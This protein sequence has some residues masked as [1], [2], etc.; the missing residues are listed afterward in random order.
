MHRTL[1]LTPLRRVSVHVTALVLTLSGCANSDTLA[2]ETDASSAEEVQA[3][4]PLSD[5][6][7]IIERVERTIDRGEDAADSIPMLVALLRDPATTPAEHG[8]ATLALS[9]AYAAVGDAE[10]AIATLE[11][12]L[13]RDSH[14]PNWSP[15]EVRA[16]LRELL[17]GSREAQG[18][19][20]R[21]NVEAP[22]FARLLGKYFPA[23]DDG[24]VNT[25][26]FIVGGDGA[27]SDAIGTFDVAAGLRAQ[28]E[29]DC[30]LC[31]E[32]ISVRTSR[33]RSDWLM[34]PADEAKFG[35]AML[36]F[37]FDLG[38][39]RIPARYERHL[40][41]KVADIER[42]LENDKSFALAAE[43]EGAPPVILI[44]APRT[45]LLE[46][47]EKHLSQLDTLPRTP[48]YVDV[49][50]R[51]R[52]SEIKGVIR[53]AYFASARACYEALLEN[54]DG[55]RG[56]I[57]LGFKIQGDGVATDV[58]IDSSDGSLKAEPF[59]SCLRTVI[60][61]VRFPASGSAI[62]TVRYPIVFAP[63]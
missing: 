25:N 17:T 45:A 22:P 31:T 5:A 48:E 37:Y 63:E 51:L 27:A 4:P 46:D 29:A 8:A 26:Y 60:E 42:E 38:K 13:A 52:P 2:S 41:M 32:G 11:K 14:G 59:V 61:K 16:R 9:R 57:E 1:S 50:L 18:I 43:R 53:S 24:R 40:P 39:N 47:V 44:A 21:K 56:R 58:S 35:D 7:I 19:E 15:R 36:V 20:P 49:S 30:P 28:Q 33:S 23:P 10:R 6:D 62:V 12:E 55:A 3:T 54:D 34:V